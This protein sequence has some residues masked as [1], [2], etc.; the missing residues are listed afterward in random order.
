MSDS[1][2]DAAALVNE[3]SWMK[4]HAACSSKT[5]FFT[6]FP[7]L[8]YE[9][10][11]YSMK[12]YLIGMG[13]LLLPCFPGAAEAEGEWYVISYV[14]QYST[15]DY[16]D[17]L[18]RDWNLQDEYLAAVGVGKEI[19]RYKELLGISVDIGIEAEGQ[20]V[21]HWGD[22]KTYQEYVGALNLRWHTF[23]WNHVLPT[24]VGT[25]MG[26]SYASR[27]PE[28][29]AA[30][31]GGKSAKLLGY[32]M[33]EVTVGLR[34]RSGWSLFFRVHHRSGAFGTFHGVRGASN[35]PCLGVKYVFRSG[36]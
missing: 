5:S 27:E 15:R 13:L 1:A 32:L 23:P 2:E 26:L 8:Y 25:G 28:H 17:L 31:H 12:Q 3:K 22:S 20:V 24:T 29:E 30:S 19:A 14:G 35:Y 9:K 16:A 7:L 18:W 6:S 36:P 34:Q 4:T 11:R 21:G 33:Y 10:S